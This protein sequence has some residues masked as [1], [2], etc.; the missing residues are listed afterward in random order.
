MKDSIRLN[1]KKKDPLEDISDLI[2]FLD[3]KFK[4]YMIA[5]GFV[6]DWYQD[7]SFN[8]I[9]I[10]IFDVPSD[11]VVQNLSK[12]FEIIRRGS[13][14]IEA[15]FCENSLYTRGRPKYR[16]QFILWYPYLAKVVNSYDF[17]HCRFFIPIFS[18][19]KE[20][21]L[22]SHLESKTPYAASQE[23]I[24][25]LESKELILSSHALK[26]LEYLRSED[27]FSLITLEMFVKRSR[28]FVGR[29]FTLVKH[30]KRTLIESVER[31]FTDVLSFNLTTTSPA[32][33]KSILL[34]DGDYI[35]TRATETSAYSN[36]DISKNIIKELLLLLDSDEK[37]TLLFS[38]SRLVRETVEEALRQQS[39]L[40]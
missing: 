18:E 19:E 10:Y 20:A 6:R 17:E 2:E 9:D 25:A 5:G 40:P 38:P 28:K 13:H 22:V 1:N 8:D 14:F 11:V 16:V 7:K 15:I 23:A 3:S 30:T 26:Q 36:L 24:N 29:D 34:E 21:V 12:N 27:S 37:S 33:F 32:I 35:E 39:A 4:S 31:V